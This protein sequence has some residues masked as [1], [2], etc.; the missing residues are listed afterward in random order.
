[1]P[2]ALSPQT[3][4][5]AATLGMLVAAGRRARRWPQADLAE[6]LGVS[7]QTVSKVEMGDPSVALGTVLEAAVLVGV[8]L[9]DADRSGMR[10]MGELAEARLALLPSRVRSTPA[11]VDDDF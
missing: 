6:R 2:R 7:R 9:F 8:P 4:D 5:A 3:I 10:T 1:M 11:K